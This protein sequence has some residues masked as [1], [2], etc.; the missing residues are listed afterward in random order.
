MTNNFSEPSTAYPIST[1]NMLETG[2][3]I[4]ILK[5]LGMINSEELITLMRMIK[6]PDVENY[7]MAKTI[8]NDLLKKVD[9]EY[10]RKT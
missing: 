3:N 6:S 2:V 5:E 4:L 9:S 10:P 7:I 1:L 8:V